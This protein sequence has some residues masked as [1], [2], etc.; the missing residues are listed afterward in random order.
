MSCGFPFQFNCITKSTCHF[1]EVD[2]GLFFLIYICYA[3]LLHACDQVMSAV[4]FQKYKFLSLSAPI[5]WWNGFQLP[6]RGLFIT[7]QTKSAIF[8]MTLLWKLI[9]TNST[10]FHIYNLL[11]RSYTIRCRHMCNAFTH[12][13]ICMCV[14]LWIIITSTAI[15]VCIFDKLLMLK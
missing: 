13:C 8:W 15:I 3:W 11:R 10:M 1:T 2:F 5:H 7:Y 4:S 9:C 14:Q 6:Y 12:D